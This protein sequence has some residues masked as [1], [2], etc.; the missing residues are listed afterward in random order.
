M[1]EKLYKSLNPR[2]KLAVDTIE[3]PVMVI[4]GPGT[5]KTTILTL[6]IAN[7]LR[8]TDTPASGILA[9]TFTESGAKAM[10]TKL[11]DIIGVRAHEVRIHTFH[12]F[13]ASI[14][15]EFADHFVH[16]HGFRQLS[17]IEAENILREILKQEKYKTL[18][19]YGNPDFYIPS[20]L[21]AISDA[22]REAYT[23]QM[24]NAYVDEQVQMMIED[25]S[26]YS[27]RGQ[28]KGELRAEIKK[29]IEKSDRTKVFAEVYDEYENIKHSKKVIDFDDLI[30]E[31]ITTLKK[32]ELLLRLIQEKYLYI[33]IDE[34]QDTNNA[35]NQLIKM[36]AD[37]F[38]IP[39][40]FIVGD[41]KQAIYRFQGASVENFLTFENIWKQIQ[42]IN[43]E[44]NYRS[45]Q[46]ILDTSFEMIENNYLGDEYQN[47]RT[48][49]KSGT[50]SDKKPIQ[51]FSGDDSFS[52]ENKMLLDIEQVSKNDPTATIAI[53]TKRNRDLEKIL[54]LCQKRGID[55]SSERSIDIFGSALGS[56]FFD[57]IEYIDNPSR[58]D[59][60]ARTLVVG[61]WDISFDEKIELLKEMRSKNNISHTLFMETLQGI[62]KNISEISPIDFLINISHISGLEK[63]IIRE[64]S[65]VEVWRGIITL[66]ENILKEGVVTNT[67]D[68]IKRLILYRKSSEN[69]SVKINIGTPNLKIS[70]MTAH[71][72]KGLEFDYV[73]LPY[74]TEEAW[75]GRTWPNYFTL[76]ISK[77]QND[78]PD[79]RRLFYV[80]ITRAK[81]HISIYFGLKD[82]E[83]TLTPLR[84]I[85]EL[86]K[87]GVVREHIDKV[88]NDL[89][90]TTKKPDEHLEKLHIDFAK[91]SILSRG[92]SV[93]ALNNFLE[94]P[95]KFLYVSI[96]RI[97]QSPSAS[98]EK[99]TAMH[100]AFSKVWSLNEKTKENILTTLIG[101]IKSYFE[102]SLLPKFEK[103]QIETELKN[104]SPILSSELL[105]HFNQGGVIF[106]EAKIQTDFSDQKNEI[107]IPLQ[108][109]LDAV[110]D[111]VEDVLVFDY[112]TKQ[113][114]S[115]NEIKGD[116]KNSNGNYFR[117]LVF[118]KYL[119]QND[120]RFHKKNIIPALVFVIPDSKGHCQTVSFEIKDDDIL[121]LKS[122]IT[123]VI[124]SVWQNTL[125]N[126]FCDDKKCP[127][128]TLKRT[129]FS[130]LE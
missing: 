34:H 28:T 55:V 20:I 47:L 59:L 8:Q 94:C 85:D 82:H 5:G 33:H 11:K 106:S 63:I 79:I 69:R 32:D 108:G 43:L 49:L 127:W 57:L 66:A 30:Y 27:T 112:K 84:F 9:I 67:I 99:G 81:K 117:Q 92:L 87:N 62:Q 104:I 18:R 1:F 95:S 41:E 102:V 118:Y 70:A 80:A 36:L 110:L 129:T 21:S 25:K 71:G 107:T 122:E 75:I 16:I 48:K 100:Y 91:N 126:S 96:L 68:L 120:I 113:V 22:K 125:I 65:N 50:N 54:N 13:A 128:C 44:E 6:R 124:D 89:I 88:R 12:G 39:N 17:D 123:N 14:I 7:I 90:Q 23:P 101:S 56:V 109:N 105:G 37:F 64:P 60:L 74:A 24:I 52:V 42:I 38:D 72:S 35:Q 77:S 19:P 86:G 121:K 2:Q 51:I 73:F 98:A 76:P 29:A 40:I 46:G 31:L 130:I 119:L 114:M 53:I 83:E 78:I 10:R 4:A 115:E 116:T 58:F 103:E 26:S 111:Q 61:L 3:G 97:P 45:H 93:T 15:S